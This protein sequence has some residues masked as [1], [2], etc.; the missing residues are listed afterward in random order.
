MKTASVSA[1]A[2]CFVITGCGGGGGGSGG[3]MTGGGG[4]VSGNYAPV[5]TSGASASVQEN[6][7]ATAYA[8]TA[9]DA[10][11]DALT[12]SL[13]GTDASLFAIAALGAVTFKTAPDFERP[14]DSGHDNT[15]DIMVTVS[16]GTHS[17]SKAVAI[18]VTDRTGTA[19]A[20]RIATGFNTPVYLVG[21]GDGSG[22][23]LVVEKGGLV[24]V[25]DPRT[26]VIDATPFLDV[27]T[28]VATDGERGLLSIALA[29]DFATSGVFY[30]YM[31]DTSGNIQIRRFIA[32]TTGV[33]AGTAGE[34][35]ISIAHARN[36]HNGGW[37]GFDASG[38]L[39]FGTG[40]GGGGGDPDGNGQ[41]KNTLLGKILRIDPRSDAYPADPNRN[42]A[43]PSGNMFPGGAGGA[44]EVWQMGLRNPF[45]NSFD[46]TTGIFYIGDVGQDLW[47]EIDM[48]RPS[49]GSL[50]FGWNIKEGNH[51]YA[52]G[53]A[54]GLTVPVAEYPHGSGPLQGN[55]E[56]GGYVY[57]GPV[58][59]LRGQYIFGDYVN[60]RIW[61]ITATAFTQGL[62]LS[63]TAFTDRTAAFTPSTGAI[64][65]ILSFG[66][67]DAQNL[68]ILDGSGNIYMVDDVG[69]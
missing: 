56:I 68:Y 30:A 31:T 34:I 37:V 39:V 66:E 49:D 33:P 69:E 59:S 14:Q 25:L 64:G 8:A 21:R 26:G 11:G 44:P 13:S 29:P 47:E 7:T 51:D 58:V 36:N 41:N 19:G 43:I 67:D 23:V 48:V 4:G 2:L 63:N 35:L 38:N 6:T 54:A 40:D 10:D 45:R 46:K 12:W 28:M 61:S 16:D 57:R 65:S 27:H 42:Y 15:Y 18:S 20:R 5:I 60:K 3:G 22:K 52:G 50:N 1:L 9:S 62:T 24:R 32:G 53:S 55:S 17:V